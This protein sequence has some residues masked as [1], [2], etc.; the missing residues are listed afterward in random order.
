M[1]QFFIDTLP[2][3]VGCLI[4]IICW[5]IYKAMGPSAVILFYHGYP[6]WILLLAIPDVIAYIKFIKFLFH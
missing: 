4:A 5:I 6:A 3:W 1:K 2:G